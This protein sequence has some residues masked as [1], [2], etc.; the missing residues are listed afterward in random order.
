MWNLFPKDDG[1]NSAKDK[2]SEALD[3]SAGY[4]PK[5]VEG[6]VKQIR[7]KLLDIQEHGRV[8]A[9]NG[10]DTDGSVDAAIFQVSTSVEK[11][12]QSLKKDPSDMSRTG[13]TLESLDPLIDLIS[14]AAKYSAT[15]VDEKKLARALENTKEALKIT[16]SKFERL[17]NGALQ[18]DDEIELRGLKATIEELNKD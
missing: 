16:A 14:R 17:H 5:Y 7:G 2:Q 1:K 15:G 4:S 12:C 8:I 11:V 6:R 3:L 9:I 18:V 10:A 13:L